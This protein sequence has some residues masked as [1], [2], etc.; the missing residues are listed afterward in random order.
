[1]GET[2][3][4]ADLLRRFAA[5]NDHAAFELLA[6]RHADAVWTVCRKVLNNHTDA[7]D[8]FQA[9]LLALARKASRIREPG[10]LAGWLYRVA[11]N[12]AKKLRADR[13]GTEPL[14]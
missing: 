8:A 4:D 14:S 9:T 13:P 12:A 2:V 3:P 1:A 6:R 10:T 11:V 7:E 5:D